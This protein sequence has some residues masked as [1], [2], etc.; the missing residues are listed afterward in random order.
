M[1]PSGAPTCRS[2][3]SIFKVVPDASAEARKLVHIV[4]D[5]GKEALFLTSSF[6]QVELS[7][8]AEKAF[9]LVA[10]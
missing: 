4:D 3:S 7:I 9:E 2:T 6:V 1:K 5:S 8:E 10:A